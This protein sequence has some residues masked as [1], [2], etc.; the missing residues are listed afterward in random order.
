MSRFRKLLLAALVG[1]ASA[2]AIYAAS[3]PEGCIP[4]VNCHTVENTA[5][6]CVVGVNC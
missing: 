4:N 6:E 2:S 3:K 5:P 1:L